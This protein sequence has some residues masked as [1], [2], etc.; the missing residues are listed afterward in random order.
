[1]AHYRRG[2]GEAP[3]PLAWFPGM[4]RPIQR[5][6]SPD[7]LGAVWGQPGDG[8]GA[9]R[10]SGLKS[11]R[12]SHLWCKES[13]SG[14]ACLPRAET[15]QPAGGSGAGWAPHPSTFNHAEHLLHQLELRI[16]NHQFPDSGWPGRW[17][18][19]S[20]LSAGPAPSGIFLQ[21]ERGSAKQFRVCRSI[22]T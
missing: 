14:C 22:R 1:M 12:L 3:T 2:Y 11:L 16:G 9:V 15:P 18:H 5:P 7:A 4:L 17:S 19:D 13:G 8:M 6:F 10:G 20:F 21:H